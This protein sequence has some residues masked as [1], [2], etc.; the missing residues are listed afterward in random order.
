MPVSLPVFLV[1]IAAVT[2]AC[3]GLGGTAA[4]HVS[5]SAAPSA[6]AQ[7]SPSSGR[8]TG[9]AASYPS[10]SSV[11]SPLPSSTGPAD[12]Q[13]PATS[14][15]SCLTGAEPGCVVPVP[16]PFPSQSADPSTAARFHVPIFEYHRVEPPAGEVGYVLNLIVPPALFDQQMQAMAADGWHTITMAELGDDLRLGMQP[17]PKS[18]V[19]TLDDGYEDGYTYAFPILRKYGYVATYFV[20]GARIGTP[21]HLDATELK[22]LLAAGSEIG[23]HTIDH[24]DLRVQTPDALRRE[25]YGASALI[26]ETIGVWPQS[27]CYPFGE[28]NDTVLAAIAATPGLETATV[29][30]GSKPETW[31]NRLILPR[32]RVGPGSYPQ[33]L[34]AKARRYVQ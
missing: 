19:V 2:L 21:G 28:T 31:A 26:A 33:I 1:I 34:V 18:F 12:S 6:I 11:A 24:V 25:V 10:P 29:E 4:G 15:P 8:S 13:A 27:F 32:I 20:V 3:T 23:N 7:A 30:G 9:P 14:G 16:S 22:T 5:P 17:A